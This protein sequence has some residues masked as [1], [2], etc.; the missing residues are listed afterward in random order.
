M[1]LSSKALTKLLQRLRIR[2]VTSRQRT[3]PN[4][5]ACPTV[6]RSGVAMGRELAFQVAQLHLTALNHWPDLC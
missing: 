5:S 1:T 2:P 6:S 4:F 3:Y